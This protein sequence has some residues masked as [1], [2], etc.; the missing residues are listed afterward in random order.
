MI[1][2]E[3]W[4][5][6]TPTSRAARGSCYRPRDFAVAG[7]RARR[8]LAGRGVE[9]AEMR[10][11]GGRRRTQRR[12][13]CSPSSSATISVTALRTPSGTSVDASNCRPVR[14]RLGASATS[15]IRPRSTY[16]PHVR[17]RFRTGASSSRIRNGRGRRS[18]RSAA[19][20][21]AQRVQRRLGLGALPRGDFREV[22]RLVRVNGRAGRRGGIARPATNPSP[23]ASAHA[24]ERE[25]VAVRGRV[26]DRA[27]AKR[28][29]RRR[30]AA[31]R[32]ADGSRNRVHARGD[33]GL[34]RADV[35]D[36]EV[37]HRGEGEADAGAEEQRR[38][39]DLPPLAGRASETYDALVSA[40]PAS[41]GGFEPNSFSA[42]RSARRRSASRPSTAPGTG[43][44]PLTE[45]PKP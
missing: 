27:D 31:E 12:S 41:S 4:A 19:Q 22:A 8:D 16:T 14:P 9:R 33:A 23:S 38:D 37:R 15:L 24:H 7:G 39:V 30:R 6:A 40:A 43:P 35:L 3:F 25:R 26:S 20:D 42:G 5:S 44:G 36:D 29:S 17:S 1:G 45:A 13:R 10:R 28:G 34:G 11:C 32:A 18:V 2:N 21:P